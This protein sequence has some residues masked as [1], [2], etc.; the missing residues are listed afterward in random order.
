MQDQ[1]KKAV[2]LYPYSPVGVAGLLTPDYIRATKTQG[3]L[4]WQ[5]TLRPQE[6]CIHCT[7]A[8]SFRHTASFLTVGSAE[9]NRFFALFEWRSAQLGSLMP[10]LALRAECIRFGLVSAHRAHARQFCVCV[11][12][13]WITQRRIDKCT[14]VCWVCVCVRKTMRPA[15][16]SVRFTIVGRTRRFGPVIWPAW[17][18][19][20]AR[21]QKRT[22]MCISALLCHHASVSCSSSLRLVSFGWRREAPLLRASIDR[23]HWR[24]Q[25]RL[26]KSDGRRAACLA[27]TET[28]RLVV[29]AAQRPAFAA[30]LLRPAGPARK[31]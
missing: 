18:R 2:R 24:A 20:H 11:F 10:R 16:E 23:G 3:R 19:A 4:S 9:Q 25:A 30:S 21:T 7:E 17:A 6:W 13:S 22:C 29:S 15:G 14:L 1:V 26:V 5:G 8:G 31:R 12:R 27:Q 28:I